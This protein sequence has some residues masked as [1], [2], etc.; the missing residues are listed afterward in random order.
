MASAHQLITPR[1]T[2][3]A[4]SPRSK[5]EFG[6]PPTALLSVCLCVDLVTTNIIG[7]N[8]S[9]QHQGHEEWRE[10]VRSGCGSWLNCTPNERTFHAD[11]LSPLSSTGFHERSF[12]FVRS[13][14][15]RS[16]KHKQASARIGPVPKA[17]A[18]RDGRA[19]YKV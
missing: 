1:A 16:K 5:R 17:D 6:P 11:F 8:F 3:S 15:S 18:A 7:R 14:I 9:S 13:L 2:S 4:R 12:V 19:N 10:F